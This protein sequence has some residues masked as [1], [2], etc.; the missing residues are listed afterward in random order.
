MNTPEPMSMCEYSATKNRT[1]LHRAVL[2]VETADEVGLAF[3]HIERQ[4]VGL[5]EER[6]EEHERADRHVKEAPYPV[7][8]RASETLPGAALE[9]NDVEEAQRAVC[10]RGVD[11]AG[12]P[13]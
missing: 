9:L 12:T 11:P 10:A 3:R 1:P 2:G 4:A 7:Q 8:R 13:G 6:D 5:G